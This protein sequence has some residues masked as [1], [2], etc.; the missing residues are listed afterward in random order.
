MTKISIEKGKKWV[1]TTGIGEARKGKKRNVREIRKKMREAYR[2]MLRN[3]IG[4]LKIYFPK[5]LSWAI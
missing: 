5:I 1:D 2:N 4:T 3:I